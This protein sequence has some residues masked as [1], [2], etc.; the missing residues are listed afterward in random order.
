MSGT[1]DL[2]WG[3][4]RIRLRRFNLDP[5]VPLD[6]YNE[7]FPEYVNAILESPRGNT[8]LGDAPWRRLR[9][10][11][12]SWLQGAPVSSGGPESS[13]SYLTA[14][15]PL[16]Y[17]FLGSAVRPPWDLVVVDG[18]S[19]SESSAFFARREVSDAERQSWIMTL[20]HEAPSGPTRS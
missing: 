9:D 5:S 12:L 2:P 20:S 7:T 17:Y 8:E 15:E 3:D 13:W 1:V 6:R 10:R 4:G 16:Q 14:F 11:F 18:R 19:S